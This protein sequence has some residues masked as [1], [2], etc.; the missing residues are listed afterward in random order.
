MNG[1]RVRKI[2]IP[3]D[4]P[5]EFELGDTAA[6]EEKGGGQGGKRKGGRDTETD[7][8]SQKGVAKKRAKIDRNDTEMD[9]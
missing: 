1:R 8:G 9:R 2:D 5:T 3:T 6:E 4:T 7:Q